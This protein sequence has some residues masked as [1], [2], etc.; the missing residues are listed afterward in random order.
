MMNPN[1]VLGLAAYASFEKGYKRLVG[2]LRKFH[3]GEII[4]GVHPLISQNEL[5]YLKSQNVTLYTVHST[6]CNASVLSQREKRPGG[7]IRAKCSKGLETLTLELGRFEMVRQWLHFCRSCRGWG[8][9]IDTRDVFFQADPFSRLPDPKTA[10]TNLYFVEE[11]SPQTSP[12]PDLDRSFVAGNF[13][14]KAHTFPCYGSRAQ[15][16]YR[17]RPVLCSGTILGTREG[18][19]RFLNVLVSEFHENNRKFNPYCKSPFT[20]DQWIMNEIYYKGLFGEIERTQTL[21]WGVGP[22]LTVGSFF[23]HFIIT[24]LQTLFNYLST[25]STLLIKIP[26]L[27]RHS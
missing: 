14:S 19:N 5:R 7:G 10:K 4:L 20:T 1:F 8:L 3:S 21:P 16:F 11:I 27:S 15:F 2:S 25:L 24:H 18:L 22:V 17:E 9:I 12:D 26:S 6:A 13:R 23:Y